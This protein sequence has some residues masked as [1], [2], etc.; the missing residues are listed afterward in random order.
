MVEKPA[1]VYFDH[2]SEV[3]IISN[4][5]GNHHVLFGVLHGE[6]IISGGF[7]AKKAQP[8]SGHKETNK[9]PSLKWLAC[10]RQEKTKEFSWSEGPKEAD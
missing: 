5:M 8:E 6:N 7:P 3:N 2:M 1:R 9:G 4:K 10:E